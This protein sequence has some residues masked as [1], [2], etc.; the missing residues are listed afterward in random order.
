MTTTPA[1]ASDALDLSRRKYGAIMAD[2]YY[3]QIA[4]CET[5]LTLD[6]TYNS[7][8]YTSPL[9]IHRQTA[10]RWS[11][12]RDLA[13]LTPRQIVR[14]ADR[15]AFSGWTNH[16]GEYVYPV[17]PFGWG[18]VRHGCGQTLRYLCKSHHPRVQK[19]RAR[20][21]RLWSQNG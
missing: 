9:G 5:G 6:K 12:H 10:R 1:H 14:I 11:G 15:I 19:Y 18:T 8:S 21:C 16:A 13:G 17:G 20:A 4:Q 7:K 3:D 2:A